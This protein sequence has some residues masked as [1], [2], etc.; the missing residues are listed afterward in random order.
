LP[1]STHIVVSST[2]SS[3]ST[4][5]RAP[6]AFL[7][8]RLYFARGVPASTTAAARADGPGT[9][10]SR[11]RGAVEPE[12]IAARAGAGSFRWRYQDERVN[13]RA[14]NR[15]NRAARFAA[16]R[17]R[18]PFNWEA[19]RR[20]DRRFLLWPIR[21]RT[22]DRW[23]RRPDALGVIGDGAARRT[24]PNVLGTQIVDSLTHQRRVVW[25]FA[26]ARIRSTTS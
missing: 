1:Q 26:Q 18:G 5:D 19:G 21:R 11:Q 13:T 16:F 7:H 3:A 14:W 20:R 23:S 15:A 9:G 12:N 2:S 8:C 24:T 22:F 25:R 10:E 17:L 4:I 6:L